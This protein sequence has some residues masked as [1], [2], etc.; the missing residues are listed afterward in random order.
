MTVSSFTRGNTCIFVRGYYDLISNYHDVVSGE[1]R[2]RRYE[3]LYSLLR[4]QPHVHHI[5]ICYGYKSGMHLTDLHI[6]YC[7]DSNSDLATSIG[8]GVTV[9]RATS[10]TLCKLIPS[11]ELPVMA[12]AL[13]LVGCITLKHRPRQISI[14]VTTLMKTL[15]SDFLLV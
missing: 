11:S 9:S 12:M 4:K 10:S 6:Q 15:A 7:L 3:S 2:C 8:G 13:Y 14:S 5:F 1:N